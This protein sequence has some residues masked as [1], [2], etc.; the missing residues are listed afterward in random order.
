MGGR[1]YAAP[2][3]F[4]AL[5]PSNTPRQRGRLF[6]IRKRNGETN[7]ESGFTSNTEFG[8]EEY[9]GTATASLLTRSGTGSVY[10]GHFAA[11]EEIAVDAPK[12]DR[13]GGLLRCGLRYL[14]VALHCQSSRERRSSLC[15]M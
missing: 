13:L 8:R 1:L 4:T 6:K 12:M 2:H 11:G 10:W 5:Q 14:G 7:V 3:Y 9:H 15:R